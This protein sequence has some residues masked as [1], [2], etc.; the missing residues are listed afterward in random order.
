MGTCSC[1]QE[2]LSQIKIENE[3]TEVFQ[4]EKHSRNFKKRTSLGSAN[5]TS[6]SENTDQCIEYFCLFEKK[7]YKVQLKSL[8]HNNKLP[9][10]CI[11]R[12]DISIDKFKEH[13]D[14]NER[15]EIECSKHNNKC[16]WYCFECELNL[17]SQCINQFHDEYFNN[18]HL[19]YNNN[20]NFL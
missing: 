8:Y 3:S 6:C 19:C 4:T 1:S 12:K 13:L 5:N 15:E 7:N 20:N 14:R 16:K 10:N 17:C 18:H 9:C 2:S 11:K